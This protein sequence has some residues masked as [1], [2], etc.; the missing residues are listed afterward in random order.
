MIGSDCQFLPPARV[1][2]QS[3]AAIPD[4]EE[5]ERAFFAGVRLPNGT[6]KT[7]ASRRLDD[8]NRFAIAHLP[9]KRK[10][11]LMDVAVSSGVATREFA[12]ALDAAGFDYELL[13]GDL[14]IEADLIRLFDECYVLTDTA[15]H[16]LQYEIDGKAF[17]VPIS[18]FHWLRFPVRL[19]MMS[20]FLR[21]WRPAWDGPPPGILRHVRRERIPLL[22]RRALGHPRIRFLT[23]DLS[24]SRKDIQGLDL[25]RAANILNVAYFTEDQLQRMVRNLLGR[26]APG[27]MLLVCRTE[28][29]GSNHGTLFRCDAGN[30]SLVARIGQGSEIERLILALPA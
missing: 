19:A 23:D 18:K 1:V 3:I 21:L 27:G 16:V 15:G 24:V 25:V 22:S 9:T 4:L 30:C 8:V 14:T 13:A 7:T 2:L 10:L 12:A 5:S 6:Y 11:R 20:L 29:D 28:D 26:L 17:A